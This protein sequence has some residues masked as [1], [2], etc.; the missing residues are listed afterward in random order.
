[1]FKATLTQTS[2]DYSFPG[3]KQIVPLAVL[4][5]GFL[6]GWLLLAYRL[7]NGEGNVHALLM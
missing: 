3:F 6:V 2:S 7:N 4:R 1:M 5:H